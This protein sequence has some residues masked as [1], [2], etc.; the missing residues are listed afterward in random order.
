MST[1]GTMCRNSH[2]EDPI[3]WYVFGNQADDQHEQLN[4][5]LILCGVH[6]DEITPVKFC[7]DTMN[8][9]KKHPELVQNRQVIIAQSSHLAHFLKNGKL[10]LTLAGSTSTAIFPQRLEQKCPEAL[11][12]VHYA[13]DPRR[14]PGNYAMSEQKLQLAQV[15][16]INRYRPDKI[17]SVHAPLT[18][19]DYDGRLSQPQRIIS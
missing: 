17:I 9:L 5:T 1:L 10:A 6:G 3:F 16:I 8:E 11:W 13:K 15:N 2:A 19:L 18:L 14:F 4:S 12:R 7:F